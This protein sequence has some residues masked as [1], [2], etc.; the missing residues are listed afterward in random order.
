MVWRF[1]LL[2]NT[3][4]PKLVTSLNEMEENL[5]ASAVVEPENTKS[6][7]DAIL[8][9]IVTLSKYWQFLNA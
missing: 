8:V 1:G 3:E 6:P 9:L 7:I 5:G 2:A 4:V